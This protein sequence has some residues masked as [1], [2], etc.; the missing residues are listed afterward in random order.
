MKLWATELNRTFSKKNKRNKKTTNRK[1]TKTT[2]EQMLSKSGNVGN[3]NQNHIKILPPI[4]L[5]C[6][7][8]QKLPGFPEFIF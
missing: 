2:H 5:L 4:Y 8:K 1:K 6:G 7:K 3:A